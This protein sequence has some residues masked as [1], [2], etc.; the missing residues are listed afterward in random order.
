MGVLPSR[1]YYYV[2]AGKHSASI[3]EVPQTAWPSC[4]SFVH[5]AMS[6]SSH[7]DR[8]FVRLYLQSNAR[9]N[10]LAQNSVHPLGADACPRVDAQGAELFFFEKGR[11]VPVLHA[12][13]LHATEVSA[14]R[15]LDPGGTPAG[16]DVRLSLG[17]AA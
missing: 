17:A 11:G 15:P 14:Q 1:R 13:R 16:H 5:I 8:F 3:D 4:Q 7:P 12:S 10:P 9:T 6:M 2:A